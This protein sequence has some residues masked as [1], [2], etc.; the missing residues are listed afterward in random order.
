MPFILLTLFTVCQAILD[1]LSSTESLILLIWYCMYSVHSFRHM[2][3]NLFCVFLSFMTLILVGFLLFHLEAVFMSARFFLTTNVSHRTLGL[4]LCLVGVYSAAASTWAYTKFSYSS[5]GVCVSDFSFS[6]STLFLSV[7]VYLSII[8][9][10]FN[11]E[12]S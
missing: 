12:Q 2:F 8:S 4:A 7:N 9:L 5:F 6:A 3:I 1:C 10:F 11:R